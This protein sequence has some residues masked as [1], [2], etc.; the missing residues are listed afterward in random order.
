MKIIRGDA[1]PPPAQKLKVS[2]WLDADVVHRIMAEGGGPMLNALL[3]RVFYLGDVVPLTSP[4][5][6]K[7]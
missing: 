3:R 4:Q 6:E 1:L 5:D 2:F 7:K